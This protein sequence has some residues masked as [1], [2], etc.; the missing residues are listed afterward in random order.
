MPKN[1]A[2]TDAL[3]ISGQLRWLV[4]EQDTILLDLAD[5]RYFGLDAVASQ[6]WLRLAAGLFAEDIANHIADQ[7]GL[8]SERASSDVRAFI[9]KSLAA[10]L[11]VSGP[12]QLPKPAIITPKLRSRMMPLTLLAWQCL[13]TASMRLKNAPF[14]VAYH[15]YANLAASS[16]A[17]I[18]APW[19]A[20]FRRAENLHP[21]PQAPK[22]CLPRSLALL[23]F[24][25]LLGVRAD[26]VIGIA[27][28]PFRAHAWVECAG[29]AINEPSDL[30]RRFRVLAR[31]AA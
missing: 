25:R 20:A 7:N 3:H 8:G 27:R 30:G 17:A 23:H 14:G 22:D 13:C 10:R 24:L 6:I 2:H 21:L 16:L 15:G 19:L 1:V 18:P 12:M 26:H 4:Y 31:L 9:C 5:G 29:L 28:D 11:L